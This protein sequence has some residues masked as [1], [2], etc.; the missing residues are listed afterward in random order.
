M[1]WLKTLTRELPFHTLNNWKKVYFDGWYKFLGFRLNNVV[2]SSKRHVVVIYRVKKEYDD[3]MENLIELCL[4]NPDKIISCYDELERLDKKIPSLINRKIENKA[5][6]KE[7]IKEIKEFMDNYCT[8]YLIKVY[9]NF[10]ITDDVAEKQPELAKK[11]KNLLS[12]AEWF[13]VSKALIKNATDILKLSYKI[14]SSLTYDELLEY[15]DAGKLNYELAEKR[16]NGYAW[17]L[18][19]NQW[20]YEEEADEYIK[21]LDVIEEKTEKT[22]ILKGTVANK[23]RAK[24]QVVVALSTEDFDRIKQGCIVVA[25]MTTPWYT[26]YLSKVQAIITD[27]GGIGCHASIIAREMNIPCIIGTKTATSVL[28]DGDLVEVDAEKGIVR[29]LK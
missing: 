26:P 28:K 6:L 8:I 15:I 27:E 21:T 23:G 7:Y 19:S 22:N 12:K 10:A 11:A 4:K 1:K 3:F 16:Y 29:R 9:S 17:E 20:L 13:E 18:A 5:Q 24:G 14:V 2:Y 25:H